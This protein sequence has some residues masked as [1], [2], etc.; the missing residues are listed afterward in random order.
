VARARIAAVCRDEERVLF[1]LDLDFAEPRT[2]S[3]AATLLFG[4][5]MRLRIPG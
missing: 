5:I 4:G 3:T 2:K 1:T